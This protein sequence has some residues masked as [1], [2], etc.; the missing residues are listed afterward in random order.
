MLMMYKD[1]LKKVFLGLPLLK[2][3]NCD[4]SHNNLTPMEM[5]R[6]L[7]FFESKLFAKG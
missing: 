4:N 5:F 1:N 7:H 3:D 2:V 6:I